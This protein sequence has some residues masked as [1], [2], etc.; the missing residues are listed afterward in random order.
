MNEK[1]VA[2]FDRL[3]AAGGILS[4]HG[5]VESDVPSPEMHVSVARLEAQLAHLRAR[6]AVIPLRELFD[7]RARGRS[8]NRCVSIT[9]DDAYCGVERLAAPILSQLDV[10]ATIFVTVEAAA[11]YDS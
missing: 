11:Q 5:V 4:Y 9:F 8:T 10:P 1:F 3:F 7:R 6:Y 2:L